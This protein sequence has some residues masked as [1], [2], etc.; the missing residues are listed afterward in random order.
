VPRAR[1]DLGGD[2]E[3]RRIERIRLALDSDL[4]LLHRLEQRRLGLGRGAVDLVGQEQMGEDRSAPEL[5][6]ALALIVDRAAGDV[7]RQQ[8]RGELDAAEPKFQR[9][10]E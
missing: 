7:A 6:A 3:K 10:A 5:E 8:V 2:D 1:W 4:P 9:L